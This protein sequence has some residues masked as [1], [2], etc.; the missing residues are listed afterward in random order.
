MKKLTHSQF[1]DLL[2]NR[3]GTIFLSIVA[4][5]QPKFRKTGCPFESISRRVYRQMVP[6]ASYA[7]AVEKQGGVDFKPAP[8]KWGEYVVP[9]KVVEYQGNLYLSG[10]FRNDFGAPI[11]SDYFADGAKVAL[12]VVKDYLVP[13]S[14]S[15][16]QIEAGV[17]PEETVEVR[18]YKFSSIKEVRVNGEHFQLVPDAGRNEVVATK[19][20]TERKG[21]RRVAT[22]E[23]LTRLVHQYINAAAERQ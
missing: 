18:D 22:T 12:E 7:N 13:P 15:K 11:E 23:I 1:K 10:K 8:R 21:R 16:R 17:D 6:G 2:A 19:K 20:V 3:A 4:E 14:P 5:T 9:D